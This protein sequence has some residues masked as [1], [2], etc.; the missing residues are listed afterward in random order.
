MY[1]HR[2]KIF[3][4]EWFDYLSNKIYLCMYREYAKQ[5]KKVLKLSIFRLIMPQNKKNCILKFCPRWGF[6]QAKKPFHACSA[7]DWE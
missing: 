4:K 6:E 2:D 5:R 3:V 1:W 7:R